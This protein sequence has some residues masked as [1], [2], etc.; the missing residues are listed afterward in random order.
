VH[1][2]YLFPG[3]QTP[4]TRICIGGDNLLLLYANER[5]RMWD[6]KT[7]EFRRSMTLEKAQEVLQQEGWIEMY[8]GYAR[9][10]HSI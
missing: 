10:S 3:A 7:R 6:A 9:D 1:S 8:E 5:A 2:L 4:L